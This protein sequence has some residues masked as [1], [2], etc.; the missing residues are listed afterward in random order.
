MSCEWLTPTEAAAHAKV[1][2]G[3][4]HRWIR[5]GL[6]EH[7]TTPSGNRRI[8]KEV[9]VNKKTIR[10]KLSLAKPPVDVPPHT[11]VLED[12]GNEVKYES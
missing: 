2:T 12:A 3:A 10:G 5:L 4:I 7:G 1:T 8:C 6:I 9:L 11:Q